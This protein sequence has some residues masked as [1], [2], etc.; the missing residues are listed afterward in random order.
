MTRILTEA[1]TIAI[2]TARAITYAGQDPEAP[3]GWENNWFQTIP[4]TSFNTMFR[5]YDPLDPWVEKSWR[6]G[7]TICLIKFD[8]G[9]SSLATGSHLELLLQKIRTHTMIVILPC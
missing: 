7:Q 3:E 9:N 8:P 2:G 6:P 5:M 4:G 1:A